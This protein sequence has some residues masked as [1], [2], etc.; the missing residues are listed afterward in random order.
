M[1]LMYTS[2]LTSPKSRSPRSSTSS[3]PSCGDRR[4]R[5]VKSLEGNH[6]RKV[7]FVNEVT[8]MS[9]SR[10]LESGEERMRKKL[11]EAEENGEL[12]QFVAETTVILEENEKKNEQ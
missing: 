9:I 4:K 6:S 1:G 5:S 11:E 8:G 3:P 2:F 10:V 7:S 12:S